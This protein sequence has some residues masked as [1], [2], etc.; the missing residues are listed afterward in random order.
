ML[1][2][3]WLFLANH[4]A[5]F[6]HSIVMMCYNLFIPLGPVM[7]KSYSTSKEQHTVLQI[8]L[9]IGQIWASLHLLLLKNNMGQLML[10]SKSFNLILLQI[11]KRF[12]LI[13]LQIVGTG[14]R[15]VSVSGSVRVRMCV[16]RRDRGVLRQE[17]WRRRMGVQNWRALEVLGPIL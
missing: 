13:L 6:Q 10:F 15:R 4:I 14:R 17:G 3:T 9:T 2:I 1:Q 7:L 5:L 8:C 16:V 12:Y 11:V